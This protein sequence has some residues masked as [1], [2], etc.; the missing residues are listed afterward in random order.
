MAGSLLKSFSCPACGGTVKIHAAG[1][2]ISAVCEHCSSV[3]DTAN[4]NF[5]LIKKEHE[6]S[7]P[8]DIPIGAKGVLDGV[9][10][11]VIGYVEKRDKSSM[12][13]WDEYLLFNPYFGF[14]FLL[15]AD[16]HWSLAR[17]FKRYL[18]QAGSASEMELD[19]EKFSVYC[20]GQS[21]VE[22]VK[23]EFYWRVRKGDS[24]EYTD[25]IAPP[26]ML[27]VEKIKQEIN[28]SL[29]EY[30]AIEAIEKAFGVEL[31]QPNGV[32]ANQPPPFF[33]T[34]ARIWKIAGWAIFLALVLQLSMDG[35]TLVNTSSFHLAQG[36]GDKNFSTPV[37]S[38]QKRSSLWVTT[39][40]DVSNNWAELDL[41]LVNEDTNNAYDARQ[42]I[43]SYS[44]YE[45]GEY[46]NEGGR[47]AESVYAAV[48]AGNY[49]LI[50]DPSIGQLDLAGMYMSVEIKSNRAVWGNFWIIV[51]FIL[52]FPVFA[53][54]YRW[55]FES[56]RW[57]NSDYAPGS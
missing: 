57:Q 21:T 45:D 10:W 53:A 49:R 44:G 15:Q 2:S 16:G 37:F 51:L 25:Y 18:A 22:Y 1:H 4:D 43:E 17:V 35:G 47:M 29:A 13:Y 24:E 23:G 31:D 19:G 9:K 30:V 42:V 12:S 26:K 8:T 34:L 14:R 27:S 7:R 3:I 11:E 46:W 41:S 28:E 38:L 54:L 6:A 5:K 32:A 20:R 55:N 39:S 33:G 56:K 52:V 36:D 50:I 48:P 40:L